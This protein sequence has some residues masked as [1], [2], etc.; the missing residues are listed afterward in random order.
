MARPEL[1]KRFSLHW[2]NLDPTIGHEI[3]KIRP[4]V[5]VS[6]DE[7]NRHLA[8]LI[9]APLTTTIRNYPFRLT[10]DEDGTQGQIA[11][12]QLRAIDKTRVVKAMGML[13]SKHH[14]T[15][16]ALLHEMFSK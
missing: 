4:V 5:I 3:K 2:V 8:T 7:M 15:V 13:E 9:V 16:I 6:P 10:I 1:L 14:D 12:D 11:L